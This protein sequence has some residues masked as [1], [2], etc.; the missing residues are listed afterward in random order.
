VVVDEKKK[1]EE[2]KKWTIVRLGI[3]KKMGYS[4]NKLVTWGIR[5]KNAV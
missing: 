3:R 1:R 4:K 5:K 2:G